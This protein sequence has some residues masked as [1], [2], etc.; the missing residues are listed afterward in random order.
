M[1]AS[2]YYYWMVFDASTGA[3]EQTEI[4]EMM[5]SGSHMK[6]L[7]VPPSQTSP[8]VVLNFK[9]SDDCGR[10]WRPKGNE[11]IPTKSKTIRNAIGQQVLIEIR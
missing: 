3:L 2:Q 5:V 11:D 9:L 7:G 10:P 1:L 6:N 4:C 8:V